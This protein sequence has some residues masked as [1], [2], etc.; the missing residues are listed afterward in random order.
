[1]DLDRVPAHVQPQQQAQQQPQQQKAGPTMP[2]AVAPAA[3][4]TPAAAAIPTPVPVAAAPAAPAAGLAMGSSL[5]RPAFDP[6]SSS[7]SE[8]ELPEIDSGGSERE[9][10]NGDEGDE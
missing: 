4:R 8:G 3:V 2:A 1:M 5:A 10:D 7:D 9:E 6:A